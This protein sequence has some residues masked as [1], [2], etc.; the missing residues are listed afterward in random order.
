M[1][2][3]GVPSPPGISPGATSEYFSR[4]S[5]RDLFWSPPGV[6]TEISHRNS[7]RGSPRGLRQG[8]LLGIP[9]GVLSR[10]FFGV[11]SGNFLLSMSILREIL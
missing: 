3:P 2:P 9:S 11:P 7:S 1:I 10:D 5:F 8:F 6:P 4:N